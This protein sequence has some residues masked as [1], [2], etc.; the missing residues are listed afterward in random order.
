MKRTAT[1]NGM[2][3]VLVALLG[4]LL[5]RPV[6][7]QLAAGDSLSDP[8]LDRAA[9]QLGSPE[10]Y[11]EA[12]RLY[13]EVLVEHPDAIEVR[14][15][16]ARVL[17]WD[18]R[19][20]E[21]IAEYDRA[22]AQ[23]PDRRD[24]RI[25]RAEVLSWK[26]AYEEALAELVAVLGE[27]P[28]N[29]RAARAIARIHRWSG[30]TLAAD[31]AYE[32]ALAIEEDA[33][34]RGE[35]A[36]LRGTGTRPDA[37]LLPRRAWDS[38]EFERQDLYVQSQWARDL[39]TRIALR[40][41]VVRAEH[42][43]ERADPR[44]RGAH[45]HARAKEISARVEHRYDDHTRLV[46]AIGHRQWNRLP[47]RPWGR[48][49]VELAPRE[50]TSVSVELERADQIDLTDSFEAAAEGL[51]HTTLRG[52][53]WA[54][55]APRIELWGEAEASR[56]TDDNDRAAL[57][58]SLSWRTPAWQALGANHS[59][60]A[61]LLGSALT[62]SDESPAY[63]DPKLDLGAS[64][65]LYHEVAVTDRLRL[66][67]GG[68]YGWGRTRERTVTESGSIGHLRGELEAHHGPWR[69]EVEAA[70]YFSQR[71][72]RYRATVVELRIVRSF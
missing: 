56:I 36:S 55:L 8:R 27:D 57:D 63:Y 9:S 67:Y 22:R 24:V 11:P 10:G 37:G 25:E 59:L 13:R 39:A 5:A 49:R 53:L 71:S 17:S 52:T 3:P 26:G 69:L 60:L 38:D 43:Q 70:R 47:D 34:L 14:I 29:G 2:V 1:A 58:A 12:I 41:G 30:R 50:A 35:W 68:G 4:M 21:A 7:A 62:Y 65:A 44:V 18:R 32:R 64:L 6:L 40:L 66:R 54:E 61:G 33:E 15:P 42:P 45:D 31:R 23:Q 28:A 19:L 72:G 16:L 20:D 48:L 51:Q 46:A